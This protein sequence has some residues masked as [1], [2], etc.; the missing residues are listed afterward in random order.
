MR[1]KSSTD[2]LGQKY[3][4]ASVVD[5]NFSTAIPRQ[6]AQ[7][8]NKNDFYRFLLSA[9]YDTTDNYKINNDVFIP[10]SILKK[11]NA[12]GLIKEQRLE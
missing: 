3:K 9:N 8:K 12:P 4:Q 7:K 1:N 5:M 11:N 2:R 6:A 10:R